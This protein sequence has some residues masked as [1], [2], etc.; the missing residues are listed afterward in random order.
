MSST[1]MVFVFEGLRRPSGRLG[2]VLHFPSG[3]VSFT[4]ISVG[5]ALV[6]C[7]KRTR[8]CD[9]HHYF[10]C[11][12]K[13]I[14]NLLQ[15]AV[16]LIADMPGWAMCILNLF[17]CQMP[18]RV[19]SFGTLGRGRIIVF[20]FVSSCNVTLGAPSPPVRFVFVSYF[21]V[22]ARCRTFGRGALRKACGQ[23]RESSSLLRIVSSVLHAAAVPPRED[24]AITMWSGVIIMSFAHFALWIG[25]HAEHTYPVVMPDCIILFVEILPVL[26]SYSFRY[27]VVVILSCRSYPCHALRG[28]HVESHL[29][30]GS[31]ELCYIVRTLAAFT[32]AW[33]RW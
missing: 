14:A 30:S 6:E 26:P 11:G 24:L 12:C 22:I 5:C 13:G 1:E 4:I 19:E 9:L 32:F 28:R 7:G 16:S 25:H 3:G 31:T 18:F 29:P 20:V 33:S 21:I 10:P 23:A 27:I 17:F 2:M 15:I 8:Y